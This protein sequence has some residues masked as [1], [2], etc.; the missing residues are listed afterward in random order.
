MNQSTKLIQKNEAKGLRAT[1]IYL[2][3]Y[4]PDKIE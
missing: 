3:K 2:S 1:T 4:L